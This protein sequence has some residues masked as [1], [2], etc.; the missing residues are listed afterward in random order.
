[1]TYTPTEWDDWY[2]DGDESAVLVDG[3]VIVLSALATTVVESAVKQLGLAAL[4]AEVVQRFGPPPSGDAGAA[5]MA[6]LAEL[7]DAGVLRT[8]G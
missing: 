3:Q 6:V 5:T 7:V 8:T 2:V 1:V 4:T